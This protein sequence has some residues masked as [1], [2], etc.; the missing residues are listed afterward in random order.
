MYGINEIKKQNS[1][2]QADFDNARNGTFCVLSSGGIL[3]RSGVFSKTIDDK[4][5]VGEFLDK[6]KGKSTGIIRS[7]VQSYFA[8]KEE[9]VTA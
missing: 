5:K 3:I 8:P 7:V 2:K 4:E 9:P 6:V 1:Q